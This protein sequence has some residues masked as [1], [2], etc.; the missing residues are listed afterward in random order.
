MHE[1]VQSSIDQLPARSEHELF[2]AW[3]DTQVAYP[4]QRCVHELFAEQ[5]A[6]TP[7][8]LA[9]SSHEGTLTYQ[10]LNH[11]ANQLAR[12]L[13]RRGVTPAMHVGLCLNRSLAMLISLL[14]ILKAGGIYV[15]FDPLYPAE[16]LAYMLRD[17]QTT[18]L[19]TKDEFAGQFSSAATLIRLDTAWHEIS[20]E[21]TADIASGVSAK[22]CMYVIYTSGSTG[23]PKGVQITH[24]SMLNLIFWHQRAF[25]VTG[26]DRATQLSS[27]AFDATGWEIWPYLTIGASVHLAEE[28]MRVSPERLRDWLLSSQITITFLPTILAES[29]ITLPWPPTTPLRIM[30]TGADQLRHYPPAT[31]PFALINNYGPSEA[32]VLATSGR[33]FPISSPMDIARA[34]TIGRPIANVQIH[35]LDEHLQPVP[36]GTS[37]EI[38]I[39]GVNLAQGYLNRPELTAERFITQAFPDAP[40]LYKTGDL[41]YYLPDGQ[42]AFIGRSDKQVK[43]RGFRIELGEI[44]TLLNSHADVRQAAVIVREDTPGD[45]RLVAYIVAE[46]LSVSAL[47]KMLC[48]HLP[49]YMI[50]T[51]F[52][53][54]AA[55]PLTP[56][57]KIDSKILPLPNKENIM[58]D[59]IK[60]T[61]QN[62]MQNKNVMTTMTPF[63]EKLAHMMATLLNLEHVEIDDNFFM[64]G[65]HSL[66][67]TQVI[68][69][70][71][72]TFR[73]HLT[74]RTLFEAPTVRQLSA[75]IE[76]AI[77]AKIM[78]M[79]EDE[80]QLSLI[81]KK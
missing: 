32:T 29:I 53:G 45:K 34:P 35:I 47:R 73:V 50:P 74:L 63:E 14:A 76:K 56:N 79:S 44:E 23:R 71:T 72:E 36:V 49:D 9:V 41:A 51:T 61:T 80:A 81:D 70:V 5:A 27:P 64:L 16:R 20:Q 62:T 22:N 58:R 42:I 57:G 8:A 10:E 66:L 3:N 69:Y 40:R 11:K 1:S 43:I 6:R 54:L 21:K 37:G 4:T 77:L 30:L 68:T 39:A 7:D 12:Y 33:I 19:I 2:A 78:A 15:P 52:V 28:E 65:G 18:L 46:R 55:L 75:A 60:N 59:S 26:A 24:E 31:L 17:S 13:R 48:S 67:G 25:E 38:Y